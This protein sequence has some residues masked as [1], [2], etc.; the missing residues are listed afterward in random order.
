ME[1]WLWE[2]T[3]IW[4]RELLRNEAVNKPDYSTEYSRSLLAESYRNESSTWER[5]RKGNSNENNLT[6]KLLLLTHCVVPGL[7][8]DATYCAVLC[9]ED[10]RMPF[11]VGSVLRSHTSSALLQLW[12][13]ASCSPLTWHA[14]I[15]PWFPKTSEFKIPCRRWWEHFL[16]KLV[17]PYSQL[18]DVSW[19][20]KC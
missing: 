20:Y 12:S 10:R 8:C 1:E 4:G 14:I 19:L 15:W 9:T 18:C 11:G 6:D 2:K 16:I 7:L 5:I 17:I 3:K 13:W